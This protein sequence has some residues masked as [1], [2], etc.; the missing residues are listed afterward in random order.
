MIAFWLTWSGFDLGEG[1]GQFALQLIWF[2]SMILLAALIRRAILLISYETSI[3][4]FGAWLCYCGLAVVSPLALRGHEIGMTWILVPVLAVIVFAWMKINV[5][6]IEVVSAHLLRADD[7]RS[8]EIVTTS[9]LFIGFTGCAPFVAA[10]A[11]TWVVAEWEVVDWV[12]RWL[13]V[14]DPVVVN[15]WTLSALYYLVA[16][17]W[18][19]SVLLSRCNVFF[20]KERLNKQHQMIKGIESTEELEGYLRRLR[21]SF[22]AREIIWSVLLLVSV[23]LTLGVGPGYQAPVPLGLILITAGFFLGSELPKF[24][25]Q[26]RNYLLGSGHLGLEILDFHGIPEPEETLTLWQSLRRALQHR[27]AL[28]LTLLVLLLRVL[29]FLVELW[30]SI[31]SG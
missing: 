5:R 23:L 2:S 13:E 1:F 31:I 8:A 18:S 29:Q 11:L 27:L 12:L 30:K 28:V 25:L 10:L 24:A 14:P 6:E 21:L 15:G 7:P 4:L 19:V 17:C 3:D 9:I 22:V 16:A 20:W 26:I